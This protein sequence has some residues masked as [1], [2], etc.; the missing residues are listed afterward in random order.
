MSDAIRF[1]RKNGRIIPIRASLGAGHIAKAAS[2][3]TGAGAAY[4]THKNGFKKSDK[5]N[6]NHKLDLASLGLSA[7]TGAIG[8]ATFATPRGLALGSAATH[9]I[10]AAGT[11]LA[12][13]SVVGK[14][15]K[16]E[17]AKQFARQETRNFLVGNAI[18]GAGILGL[19]KN[20]EAAAEYAVKGLEYSKKIL[21]F[22]KKAL[23][24][25]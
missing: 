8:A 10:D 21:G 20:R 11:A 15:H 5:I 1:I 16:K 4:S 23:R 3:A 25:I 7:A 22:A 14:G 12:A 24:I 17:R 2:L 9:V 6:V 19:K 13:A 18:Y